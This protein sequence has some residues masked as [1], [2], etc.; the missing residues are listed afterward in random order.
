ML[1]D[2]LTFVLQIC[3]RPLLFPRR[4]RPKIEVAVA[5]NFAGHLL[6]LQVDSISLRT[7]LLANLVAERRVWVV[8]CTFFLRELP[9]KFITSRFT[10][11]LHEFLRLE[12]A[13][14]LLELQL[15]FFLKVVVLGD[16]LEEALC[17]LL[18][19]LWHNLGARYSLIVSKRI[20]NG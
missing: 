19:V 18:K 1:K 5:F 15:K 16:C 11:D 3:S 14:V 7:A 4:R 20:L 8:T 12:P 6:L 10:G 17:N 2:C 9:D 13:F